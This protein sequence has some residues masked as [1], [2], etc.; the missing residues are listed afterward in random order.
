[1]V[2]TEVKPPAAAA[3]VPVAI[4]S[5]CAL[6]GLAQVHVQ[7]DEARGD[8]QSAGIELLVRAA[9]DLVGSGN[10]GDA[11]IFQQHVHGRVDASRRIDEMAAL[12]QQTGGLLDVRRILFLFLSLS[13]HLPH[14]PRQN[15]HARGHAVVHFFQDARL[16]AVGDFAGEFQAAN[17][18]AGMHHDGIL[19]RHL[20]PRRSHL[21]AR[22]VFRQGRFSARRAVLSARAAA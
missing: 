11:A 18:R 9:F 3:A 21:V 8:D 22:D 5:L 12:D 20:Q 13:S 2:Q 19:L 6:A 4:V 7:I 16:R 15:R 14:R 17:D 1:M 10:F